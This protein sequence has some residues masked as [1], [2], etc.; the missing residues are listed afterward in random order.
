MDWNVTDA[1]VLSDCGQYRYWLRRDLGMVGSRPVVFVMLNPST[2]DAET[3]DPT[4]RRCIDFAK[5]FDGRELIVVNLFAWQATDKAELR[6]V[7]DPVGPGRMQF[8][9]E[10]AIHC[11]AHG[12][13]MVAAWGNDGGFIGRDRR[14]RRLINMTQ[15][16]LHYLRL[17]AKGQP[18]HPL[19]LPKTLAPVP[20]PYGEAV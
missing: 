4:I 17:T 18:S 12:G 1:A 10:A 16:D 11:R 19:Y 7:D 20:W 8:I 6:R 5:R 3:D 14:V 15:V 13:L 2:A 9:L